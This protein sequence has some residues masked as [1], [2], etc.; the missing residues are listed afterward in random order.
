MKTVIWTLQYILQQNY[1]LFSKL[2]LYNMLESNN[3]IKLVRRIKTCFT[4]VT[5]ITAF[6][7]RPFRR[8]CWLNEHASFP[9]RNLAKPRPAGPHTIIFFT[10]LDGMWI[11]KTSSLLQCSGQA[12]CY[13]ARATKLQN[14]NPNRWL[15][16][17]P[18]W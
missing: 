7:L 13:V 8:W 6:L 5:N 9:W 12:T 2:L 15:P 14:Q 11:I 17:G 3:L 16:W 1:V 18:R 4:H 10:Q